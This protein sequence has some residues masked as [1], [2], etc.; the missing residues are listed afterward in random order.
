[1]FL[2]NKLLPDQ[3]IDFDGNGGFGYMERL[4]QFTYGAVL[5]LFNNINIEKAVIGQAVE[6]IASVHHLKLIQGH[7]II[8]AVHFISDRHI[9]LL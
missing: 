7:M 6:I 5:K 2:Q 3:F 4:G 1:M 8:E 9:I